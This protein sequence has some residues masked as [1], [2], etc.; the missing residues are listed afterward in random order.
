[1]KNVFDGLI[2]KLEMAEERICTL[3]DI[4]IKSLKIRR[5]QNK[6]WEK[7]DNTIPKDCGTTIKSI[8]YVPW[9]HL[10]KEK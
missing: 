8:T 10:Q 4:S 3:E 2:S 6:D 9:E 1:M 7:N 5:K